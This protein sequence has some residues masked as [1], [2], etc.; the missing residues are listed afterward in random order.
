MLSTLRVAEKFTAPK[1]DG[2]SDV[3]LFIQQFSDVAAANQWTDTAATLHLRSHLHGT[4]QGCGQGS[5]VQE[6]LIAL[7]S[8]FGM[9]GRQAKEKLMNLRRMVDQPLQELGAEVQRLVGLAFPTLPNI[10]KENMCVDYFLRVF[11]NKALQRHM[12]AIRPTTLVDAVQSVDE[13]LTAG[14]YEKASKPRV[15]HV[16]DDNEYVKNDVVDNVVDNQFAQVNN[17][18]TQLANALHAQ[19][20]LLSKMMQSLC[21]RGEPVSSVRPPG[22]PYPPTCYGCGGLGHLVKQC[23]RRD[24]YP[25]PGNGGGLPEN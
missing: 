14:G 21:S 11:D 10:E 6:I 13:Y 2:T 24:T 1:Y 15:M 16:E 22:R 20:E 4:A 19:T 5:T 23:P 7:R 12:L 9:T 3:E 25:V 18:L 8:R 17:S